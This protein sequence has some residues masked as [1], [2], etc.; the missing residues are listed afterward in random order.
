[1]NDFRKCIVTE[2][3]EFFQWCL[4]QEYSLREIM[5]M[6]CKSNTFKQEYLT[7]GRVLNE[8]IKQHIHTYTKIEQHGQTEDHYIY[9]NV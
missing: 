6:Y 3:L 5:D 8:L 2:S 9:E 4:N 1:M 7:E